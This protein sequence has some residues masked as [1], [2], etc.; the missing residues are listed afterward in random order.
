[1]R[2]KAAWLRPLP[3]VAVAAALLL[4]VKGEG[5]I[6]A[7]LADG[8]DQSLIVADNASPPAD[9]A[10][11]GENESSGTVDVEVGLAKRRLEMDAREAAIAERAKLLSAA[12][13]RIEGKIDTL[14]TL[15]ERIDV[16][17]GKRD[18]SEQQQLAALVKTYTAMKPK[19][20][21]RIFNSLS[22]D[23]LVPVAAAMK[24]D[25][26]APVL[27]AMNPDNAEKLTVK[28]ANRLKLPQL[29][30][31]PAPEPDPRL[32]CT[33]QGAEAPPAKPG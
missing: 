14:K 28:L 10:A 33:P 22:D 13:K 32:I 16:L 7:A 18:E 3:A 24:A 25:A 26:L 11:E 29:A 30:E 31:P 6:R 21:A 17:L 20:A 2:S 23:V 9:I 19:D 4:G 1:M 8:K 12:E 27:A 15:Q 5:L